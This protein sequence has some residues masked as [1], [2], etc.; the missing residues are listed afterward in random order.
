MK[1]EERMEIREEVATTQVSEE[2][3]KPRKLRARNDTGRSSGGG[4]KTNPESDERED[5]AQ[6]KK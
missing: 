2:A 3:R 1:D 6:E 5:T 4:N